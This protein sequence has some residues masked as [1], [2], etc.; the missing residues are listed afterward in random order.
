[1]DVILCRSCTQPYVHTGK[2]ALLAVSHINAEKGTC[3][4]TRTITLARMASSLEQI[5]SHDL[6]FFSELDDHTTERCSLPFKK[7]F[8]QLKIIMKVLVKHNYHTC[9]F[10][11]LISKLT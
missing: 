10:Y 5:G 3:A 1:M 2:S 7:L 11:L 4:H 9:G 6:V 8:C